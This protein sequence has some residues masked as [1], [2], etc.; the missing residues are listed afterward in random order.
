ME[1]KKSSG[2]TWLLIGIPVLI[3]AGLILVYAGQERPKITHKSTIPRQL[4][5]VYEIGP[6]E[7][8]D[9]DTMGK[10]VDGR[11]RE[12]FVIRTLQGKIGHLWVI[13]D[14]LS[15][16]LIDEEYFVFEIYSCTSIGNCIPRLKNTSE[17]I[18]YVVQVQVTL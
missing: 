13:N 10:S 16:V 18:L 8:K 7:I 17:D 5:G 4:F 14:T 11:P 2:P 9:K 6:G 15:P 3:V 12:S 1:E